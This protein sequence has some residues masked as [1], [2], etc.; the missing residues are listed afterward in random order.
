MSYDLSSGLNESFDFKV[1]LKGK[2][3]KYV[4]R[5]PSQKDITPIQRAYI[6]LEQID[7]ELSKLKE[8]DEEAKKKLTDEAEKLGAEISD[9]FSKLFESQEDSMPIADLLENLPSNVK[10]KFDEMI[11]KEFDLS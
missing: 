9:A 4:V 3:H 1:N 7:K 10:K 6:R 11:Q 5:Y 8:E 2:E